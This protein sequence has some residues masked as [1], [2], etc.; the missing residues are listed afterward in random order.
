MGHICKSKSKPPCDNRLDARSAGINV[1]QPAWLDGNWIC[2]GRPVSHAWLVGM[3]LTDVRMDMYRVQPEPMGPWARTD[4]MGVGP[5][6]VVWAWLSQVH[7]SGAT[8]RVNNVINGQG[9]QEW[10]WGWTQSA[11]RISGVSMSVA[12][13]QDTGNSTTRYH[14]S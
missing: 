6:H 3:V 11:G 9:A 10:Q 12:G 4:D 13:W 5:G 2:P 1:Y 8:A 14:T 7:V